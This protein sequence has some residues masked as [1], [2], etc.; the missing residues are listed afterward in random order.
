MSD[1]LTWEHVNKLGILLS[2]VHPEI[3]PDTIALA[4]VHR[5][6]IALAEFKGDPTYYDEPTLQAIR[7]A[8]NTEYLERTRSWA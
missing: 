3:Q 2:N 7:D 4:D 8:W 5:Y 1:G 6:V